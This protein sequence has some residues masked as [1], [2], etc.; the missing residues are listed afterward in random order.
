MRVR[1]GWTAFHVLFPAVCLLAFALPGGAQDTAA[2]EQQLR[3]RV[4]EVYR[5][6]VSGEW[7]KVEQY[8]SED[9]RDLWFA[10][11]KSGIEGFQI[12]DIKIDPDGKRAD[13]IVMATFRVAQVPDPVTMA[14]RG[15]WVLDDGVWY[16]KVKK[17]PSLYDMFKATG[18]PS[19]PQSP[20]VFEQNP[21]RLP[22]TEDGSPTVVRIPLQNVS[23]RAI[24]VQELSTTCSCLEAIMDRLQLDAQEHAVLTVTY[25]PPSG[26]TPPSSLAIRAVLFT[27]AI[28]QLELPVLLQNP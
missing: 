28:Y 24:V 3:Q 23:S 12:K 16:L 11:P 25:R 9:A 26:Q 8:V 10:Q 2:G 7:R 13:V 14:Q 18:A 15:E 4:E 1:V 17:V 6:F 22:K 21:V 20:F 5:L 27:P 19:G